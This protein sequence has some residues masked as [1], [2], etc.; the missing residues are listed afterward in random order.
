MNRWIRY[1]IKQ[2][3][4]RTTDQKYRLHAVLVRGGSVIVQGRNVSV[5][6]ACGRSKNPC[7]P[8]W[9]GLHAEMD[10]VRRATP[11]QMAGATL[12]VGG[13]SPAGNLILTRPCDWCW[14]VLSSLSLASIVY[15]T[16]SGLTVLTKIKR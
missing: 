15:H 2:A 16:D 7:A 14:D 1:C 4:K 8:E 11:E 3:R 6:D 10:C 12:Y 9:I 13:V 5:Q